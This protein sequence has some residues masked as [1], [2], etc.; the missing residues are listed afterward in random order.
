MAMKVFQEPM[1][2]KVFENLTAINGCGS[3]LATRLL[4]LARPDW[5]VVVNKKSFEGLTK[6]FGMPVPQTVTAKLYAELLGKVQ[7][8]PWWK[9]LEPEIESELTLWKYRAALIDP[10]VYN[11]G[12]GAFDD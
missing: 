11:E 7:A 8:Q 4:L 5:F 9:S 6:R 3:A 10:L 1:V 2:Q 12:A